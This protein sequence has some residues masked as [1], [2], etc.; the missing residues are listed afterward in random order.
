MPNW[1]NKLVPNFTD[2][3]LTDAIEQHEHSTD[4]MT[5]QT[6][7]GCVREWERRRGLAQDNE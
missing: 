4:L 5:R 1:P 7:Q 3:E 6:A 2:D